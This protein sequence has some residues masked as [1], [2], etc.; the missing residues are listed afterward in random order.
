LAIGSEQGQGL[1][2]TIGAKVLQDEFFEN[3]AK[4]LLSSS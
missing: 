3:H 1:P 2:S 4:K